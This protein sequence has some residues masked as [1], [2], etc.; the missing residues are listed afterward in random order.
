VPVLIV[1]YCLLFLVYDENNIAHGYLNCD[2]AV[3][4]K[5][6]IK[7]PFLENK[8]SLGLLEF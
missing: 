4:K 8:I 1:N 5:G 3:T 6:D 2:N 7:P